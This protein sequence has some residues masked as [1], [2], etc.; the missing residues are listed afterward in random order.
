MC[1]FV[2][3]GAILEAFYLALRDL[4][5]IYV[6]KNIYISLCS[7]RPGTLCVYVLMGTYIFEMCYYA[8]FV[9]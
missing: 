3:K 6:N 1:V 4:K 2:T 5:A 7:V 9:R 8:F